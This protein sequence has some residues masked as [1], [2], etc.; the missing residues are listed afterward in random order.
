MLGVN[1]VTYLM[2]VAS[3]G[4]ELVETEAGY[5]VREWHEDPDA[6]GERAAMDYEY[7]RGSDATL[8]Y[9]LWVMCDGWRRPERSHNSVIP[10]TVATEGKPAIAAWIYLQ[11][12]VGS[13]GTRALAADRLNV[14]EHTIS[15]YLTRVR[16]TVMP[17]AGNS[18]PLANHR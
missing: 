7:D 14:S 8:H 4:T 10:I 1:K 2:G 18:S 9:A 17:D 15:R 16:D 13:P 5:A 12:G 11:G 3:D 6:D